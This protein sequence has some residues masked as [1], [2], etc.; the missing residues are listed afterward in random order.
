MRLARAIDEVEPFQ[1]PRAA[2]NEA[3]LSVLLLSRVI[4]QLGEMPAVTPE[5]VERLFA[6]DFV[7]LQ[8]VY[9]RLNDNASRYVET[10]CPSCGKRFGLDL[11]AESTSGRQAGR[12]ATEE[13][14]NA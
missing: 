8:E 12:A 10:A 13:P 5:I 4:V 1:D 14:G 9:L 3:Y 6:S 2:T 11:M 7:Y